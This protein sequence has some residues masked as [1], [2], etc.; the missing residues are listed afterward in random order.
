[1]ISPG[2]YVRCGSNRRMW[3]SAR[4]LVR[5]RNG[6]ARRDNKERLFDALGDGDVGGDVV[7]LMLYKWLWGKADGRWQSVPSSWLWPGELI[8]IRHELLVIR[9]NSQDASL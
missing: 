3:K 1:S 5:E 4:F 7:W 2:E 8:C 6:N 9:V